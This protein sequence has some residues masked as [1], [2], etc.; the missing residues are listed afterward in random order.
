VY[1]SEDRRDDANRGRKYACVACGRTALES[2]GGNTPLGW[3][4]LRFEGPYPI[5]GRIH[6]PQAYMCS[7]DCVVVAALRPY[8]LTGQQVRDWL[9]PPE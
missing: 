7:S 5:D 9:Y 1:G 3:Y 4:K 6:I 2:A 8:G